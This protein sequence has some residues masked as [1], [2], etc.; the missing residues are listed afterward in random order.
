M[1]ITEV[2]M[3]PGDFRLPMKTTTPWLMDTIIEA[4]YLIITPQYLGDPRGFTVDAL[5]GAARYTGIVT[6]PRWR[7]GI[8][9]LEG[10]GLGWLLGNHYGIGWPA[11]SVTYAS[12][13][14]STVVALQSGGGL[15]PPLF[16]IGTV[17]NTASTHGATWAATDTLAQALT[18]VMADCEAHYKINADGSIDAESVNS[19]NIYLADPIVVAT[20]DYGGDDALYNGLQIV[21][22]ESSVSIEEWLSATGD[23]ILGLNDTLVQRAD[24]ATTD[25]TQTKLGGITQYTTIRTADWQV[26]GAGVGD[27]IYVF[28]PGSG[29]ESLDLVWFRGEALQPVKH[30]IHEHEWEPIDGMGFYYYPPEA[31]VDAGDIVDL[32]ATVSTVPAGSASTYLRSYDTSLNLGCT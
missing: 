16:S 22:I 6:R 3:E 17:T 27:T 28:D 10:S 23:G 4:G 12:D 7:N 5:M 8:L 19:N 1:A 11:P 2:Y 20:R 9:T 32:T 13:T 24:V 15:I 30:R 21:D 14:L 31:S 26:D 29:F 18:T 25:P